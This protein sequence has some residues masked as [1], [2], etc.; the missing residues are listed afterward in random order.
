VKEIERANDFRPDPQAV[1][2]AVRDK[3]GEFDYASKSLGIRIE[4][5]APGFARVSMAVQQH[6]LNGFGMCHGGVITTLA[7]TAFAYA[8]NSYNELTV[9][10]G[11]FVEILNPAHEGDRLLAV[12]REVA[13][14]G[15]QGIYDIVVTNQHG[16]QVAMMRGRSHTMKGKHLVEFPQ[17]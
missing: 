8:C 2:E 9:A 1:A 5:V 15:R 7:D 4:G 12:A 10:T 13:L 6:M 14:N 11:I 3:M 17:S 16:K